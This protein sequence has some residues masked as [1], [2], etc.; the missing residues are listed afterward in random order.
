MQSV[1][2]RVLH[3][4]CSEAPNITMLFGIFDTLQEFEKE[5]TSTLA[6]AGAGVDAVVHIEYVVGCNGSKSRVRQAVEIDI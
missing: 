3:T 6:L 4:K 5:V 2:E 1:F